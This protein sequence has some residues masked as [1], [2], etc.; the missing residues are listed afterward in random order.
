MFVAT[1]IMT[2]IVECGTASRGSALI[3]QEI[4]QAVPVVMVW[5]EIDSSVVQKRY[6]R[7][8]VHS[9]IE[10]VSIRHPDKHMDFPLQK[11]PQSLPITLQDMFQIKVITPVSV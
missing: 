3:E 11:R 2:T 4:F 6:E 8:V 7:G 5:D 1:A 9:I 10:V